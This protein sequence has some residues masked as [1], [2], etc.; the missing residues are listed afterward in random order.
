MLG[1]GQVWQSPPTVAAQQDAGH[2]Q[3]QAL[4]QPVPNP[5]PVA[6]A[7]PDPEREVPVETTQV[8]SVG[9]ARSL[10]DA[11][12]AAALFQLS[13]AARAAG[14]PGDA[15]R[16]LERLLQRF[17][18]DDR[19]ALAAFTLARLQLDGLSRPRV[20][21]HSLQRAHALGLPQALQEDALALLVRAYSAA[22]DS[23]NAARAAQGYRT[24]YPH[25][26]FEAAV[27]GWAAAP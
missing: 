13:D 7:H 4:E 22:G 14:Q 25:G 19:A 23:A 9:F 27:Q 15:A 17:P 6:S 8:P 1:A 3:A 18:R 11:P 10:R 5:A 12:D 2:S 20:A 16:A 24:Q 21:V 26:R